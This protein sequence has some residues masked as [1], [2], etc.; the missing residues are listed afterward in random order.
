MFQYV[1]DEN[2]AWHLL[3][4]PNHLVW[5]IRKVY[6]IRAIRSCKSLY[7]HL[8]L[9]ACLYLSLLYTVLSFIFKKNVFCFCLRVH[10]EISSQF[11][12]Q[13]RMLSGLEGKI[14]CACFCL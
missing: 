2:R 10:K 8:L 7:A 6:H 9:F 14:M 3:A 11:A 12:G 13:T 4:H 1:M 5:N